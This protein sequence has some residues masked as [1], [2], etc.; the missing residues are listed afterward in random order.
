M[1]DDL[2]LAEKRYHRIGETRCLIKISN[3]GE[4]GYLYKSMNDYNLHIRSCHLE[5]PKST[6]TNENEHPKIANVESNL[7]NPVV[8]NPIFESPETSPAEKKSFNFARVAG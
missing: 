4:C 5:D 2:V 3:A 7:S 8:A 6:R 1:D